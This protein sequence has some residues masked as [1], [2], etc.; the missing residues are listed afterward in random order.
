[1]SCLPEHP[2]AL[3]RDGVVVNVAV[4]DGH[5]HDLAGRVAVDHG[6]DGVVCLCALGSVPGIGDIWTGT[7]FARPEEGGTP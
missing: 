4:F 2:H 6:A 1:M 5:D 3:L 7:G